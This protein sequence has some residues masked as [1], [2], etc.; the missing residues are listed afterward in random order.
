M[1]S[2]TSFRH[3]LLPC[4]EA[5]DQTDDDSTKDDVDADFRSR[6]QTGNGSAEALSGR[7][8]ENG[9]DGGC[10]EVWHTV[11][12]RGTR[13]RYIPAPPGECDGEEREVWHTVVLTGQRGVGKASIVASLLR[14]DRT[15]MRD[16]FTSDSSP[17]GIT[18]ALF[19]FCDQR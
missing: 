3:R 11:D 19:T 9:G 8:E 7:S 6:D 5:T 4:T 1:R 17:L 18:Y 16:S 14:S 2:F 13:P 15:N 10:R 12:R